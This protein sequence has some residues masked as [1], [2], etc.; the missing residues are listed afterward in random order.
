M[1]ETRPTRHETDAV[2][3][4][5]G[6]V[7]LFAVFQLGMLRLSCHL[8]DALPVPGGQLTALYPEKPIYDIPG[9]P[10]ILAGDL[11]ERLTEQAAPFNPQYH[12]GVTVTALT[13]LPDGRWAVELSDGAS[14]IA[15]VVVIAAGPGAFG[16]NRPPLPG[17]ADFE[18]RSVFYMVRRREDLRGR[19]VVIAGGGD[20]AVDWAISLAGLAAEVTVIHRRAKFRAAPASEARL[21]DLVDSRAITLVV[22]YQLHGLEGRDGR[23]TAVVVADLEG[24]TRRLPADVLLAFFGL[25]SQLGPIAQWGLAMDGHAITVDPATMATN[26]PGV[27]AIGD[28]A[29]YAGKLKLILQGFSEGAVAAHAAF[30]V[31]RPGQA[32]HFEHSTTSG[33]PAAS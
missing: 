10:T 20:S 14:L 31:A 5:A 23:L 7:G 28:I 19:R 24:R 21:H 29:G 9:F 15:P 4:G 30:A 3:I 18:G 16:P 26:L 17:L 33:V 25:A 32:L 22:P 27:Y 1:T 11:V 2:I 6:P 12:L 8:V 13:R